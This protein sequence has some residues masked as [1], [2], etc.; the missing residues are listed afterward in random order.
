MVGEAGAHLTS[1]IG[2][3]NVF[4]P[5][6]GISILCGFKNSADAPILSYSDVYCPIQI[7]YC[8]IKKPKGLSQSEKPENRRNST[9]SQKIF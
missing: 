8:L 6:F 9:I 1:V 2:M 3:E 7:L 4:M 5:Q